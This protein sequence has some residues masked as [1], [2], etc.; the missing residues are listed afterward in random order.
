MGKSKGGICKKIK[1][2]IYIYRCISYKNYKINYIRRLLKEL[3]RLY[4]VTDNTK[5]EIF[6]LN[7][8]DDYLY[9][10]MKEFEIIIKIELLNKKILKEFMRKEIF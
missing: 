6:D 2:I 1:K 7:G 8:L 10:T 5:D 9:K 3:K 4:R